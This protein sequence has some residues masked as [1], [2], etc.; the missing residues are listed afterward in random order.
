MHA[1]KFM[2]IFFIL[3]VNLL[4][5]SGCSVKEYAPATSVLVTFKSDAFRF[6]DMGYIR[7][8]SRGVE[9]ELFSAGN[10]VQNFQLEDDVCTKK[11][12]LNYDAFNQ[13]YLHSNYPNEV[14]KNI[15][16]GEP[17]FNKKGLQKT[18]DGFKQSIKAKTYNVI[19]KIS[20]NSIYFKDKINGILIKIREVQ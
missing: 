15:F 14:L 12:C 8:S 3:W 13:E 1:I 18:D 7:K 16:R 19:Y 11:G 4:L 9:V 2:K 5:F 10:L 17:I 6:S 20:N